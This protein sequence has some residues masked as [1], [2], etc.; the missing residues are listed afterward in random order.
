MKP[1]PLDCYGSFFGRTDF[2]FLSFFFFELESGISLVWIIPGV[3]FISVYLLI[4][5]YLQVKVSSVIWVLEHCLEHWWCHPLAQDI[6]NPFSSQ[7]QSLKP[8]NM[9]SLPCCGCCLWDD[10]HCNVVESWSISGGIHFKYVGILKWICGL[11]SVDTSVTQI[12]SL[13]L[14]QT[15]HMALVC[16]IFPL[17]INLMHYIPASH[18]AVVSLAADSYFV[19]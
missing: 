7:K 12:S 14:S 10:P 5:I 19:V 8:G 1:L 17:S 11:V 2:F 13:C 3:E 16:V 15:S 4:F 18:V 9:S 6:K